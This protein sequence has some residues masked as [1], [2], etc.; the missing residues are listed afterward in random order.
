M[1]DKAFR[2]VCSLGALLVGDGAEKYNSQDWPLSDKGSDKIKMGARPATK[3]NK[4][5]SEYSAVHP[6]CCCCSVAS[7]SFATPWTVA[8]QAP[9]SI[10]FSRQEY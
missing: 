3:P 5:C 10:Q 4:V 6:I 8:H 1:L 7:D 2:S 9:L